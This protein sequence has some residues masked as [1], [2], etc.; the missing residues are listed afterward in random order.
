MLGLKEILY[1]LAISLQLSGALLIVSNSYK[2][3]DRDNLI[4]NFLKNSFTI[5]TQEEDS[6]TK[7]DI[8]SYNHE[9]FLDFIQL[10]Y[11]NFISFIYIFVGYVLG[12]LGEIYNK[13]LGIIIIIGCT[14]AIIYITSKCIKTKIK[15][16]KKID[17]EELEKLNIDP[18]LETASEEYIDSLFEETNIEN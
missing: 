4:K 3:L 16:T 8:L 12:V 18:N 2:N 9:A 11:K 10:Q 17:I 13:I 1:C 14:S 6:E 7:K 15:K 5:K